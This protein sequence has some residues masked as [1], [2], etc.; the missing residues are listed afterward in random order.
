M[1]V[2][3]TLRPRRTHHSK[4]PGGPGRA[5][6]VPIGPFHWENLAM[7]R[8]LCALATLAGLAAAPADDPKLAGDW[9]GTLKVNDDVSL[10]VVFHVAKADDGAYTATWDSPDQGAKGMKVDSVALDGRKAKLVLKAAGAEFA[11]TLGDDGKSLDGT[12]TQAGKPF[13]LKLAPAGKPD[14]AAKPDEVWSGPIEVAGGIELGITLNLFKQAD[15]TLKATMDV[16]DQGAE[17]MKVDSVAIDGDS[18]AFEVKPI[19]GAFAGKL[20]KE[21]TEAKGQWT[22]LGRGMPLTLKKGAKA[23]GPKK[24]SQ[25]LKGPF[26]YREVAVEYPNNAA[27]GVTLAATLTE[28]KGDGP[29][30]AV[31]LISGSG[32]QDRDETLLGHKPFLVLADY[33]TR[34]GIAVL[35]FDDRGTGASTGD[36]GAATSEDFATDAAAGVEFLKGRKEIDPKQIGLMGHSE[37]GLI[38]PMVAAEHPDDIAFVVLLAGPGVPG[39]EIMTEQSALIQKAMGPRRRRD[40]EEHGGRQEDLRPDAIREGRGQAERR[41]RR[42]GQGV[43]GDPDRRRPESPGGRPGEGGRGEPQADPHPLVPLLPDLRPPAHAG[44]GE[45]P[46]PGDQRRKRP[47]GPAQ[48]EPPGDRQGDQVRRQRRGDD[49]GNARPEPPVPGKQDRSAE[50]IRR[51]RGDLQPRSAESHRRLDRRAEVG[52]MGRFAVE[53]GVAGDF[54]REGCS[55]RGLESSRLHVFETLV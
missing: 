53:V 50:R 17:G 2:E 44:E 35:R 8:M 51:D 52:S 14:D 10:R 41:A 7:T 42:P 40:R 32:P 49:K 6:R 30:P 36:H 9:A 45:V 3:I 21:K 20:N 26:P 39:D 1:K 25:A 47:P 48:P 16:P 34:R 12:F 13:P 5:A 11:G 4:T 28:P 55:G 23:A 37:G 38:A 29:F 22:Q 18:F 24:R 33:L 46:G 19:K 54:D 43:A 15:G 31:V 27:K